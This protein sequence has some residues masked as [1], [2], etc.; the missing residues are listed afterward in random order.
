MNTQHF[1]ELTR[2]DYT[3]FIYD[4]TCF[5][6]PVDSENESDIIKGINRAIE[7]ESHP[8]FLE[9]LSERLSELGDSCTVE[10]TDTMLAEVKSR[11]NYILKKACPRTVIE[12]IKGTTPGASNRQN[13][14]ELCYALEMDFKQTAVFFQKHFS[15]SAF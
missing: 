14:Y 2:S 11:Y 15:D 1:S 3:E 10:D 13:N 12:W 7:L 5:G 9:G 4:T 6:E 8:M